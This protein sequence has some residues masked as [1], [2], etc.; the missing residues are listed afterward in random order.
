M[1][2]VYDDSDICVATRSRKDHHVHDERDDVKVMATDTD[3]ADSWRGNHGGK[4]H[5][6][7]GATVM[8]IDTDSAETHMD[9]RGMEIH[10]RDSATNSM[11][12]RDSATQL[13]SKGFSPEFDS[14]RVCLGRF[15][16]VYPENAEVQYEFGRL[17]EGYGALE[18]AR[19]VYA[20]VMRVCVHVNVCVCVCL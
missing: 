4:I 12:E 9:G 17:L 8:N 20:K 16:D 14:P 7:D 11:H 1:C 13:E 18:H 2:S 10:E 6:H 3:S 5:E 15:A 19:E